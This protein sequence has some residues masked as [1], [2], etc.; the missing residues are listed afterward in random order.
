MQ[1]GSEY[2]I[3]SRSMLLVLLLS[4]YVHAQSDP[5]SES[6][7]ELTG[8]RLS[9]PVSPPVANGGECVQERI[10]SPGDAA[11]IVLGSYPQV[12]MIN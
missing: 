7:S 3:S 6:D 2:A 4:D 1:L 8:I 10:Y 9:A 5:H 12:Y 11:P